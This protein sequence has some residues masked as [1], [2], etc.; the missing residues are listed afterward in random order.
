MIVFQIWDGDDIPKRCERVKRACKNSGW[1]YHLYTGD[2][3]QEIY[4]KIKTDKHWSNIYFRSDVARFHVASEF[5]EPHLYCDC[6]LIFDEVPILTDN[7][8]FGMTR[9]NTIDTFLF[10]SMVNHK[11]EYLSF[12]N[13]CLDKYYQFDFVPRNWQYRVLNTTNIFINIDRISRDFFYHQMQSL[14]G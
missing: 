10:G 5:E 12:L 13:T 2:E 11:E 1:G 6:D 4:S 14:R 9:R 8:N 7:V 3:L